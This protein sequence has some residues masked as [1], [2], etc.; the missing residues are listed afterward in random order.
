MAL[1]A[2]DRGRCPVRAKEPLGRLAAPAIA[3][4]PA[5]IQGAVQRRQEVGGPFHA[6][7]PPEAAD[8]RPPKA[9]GLEHGP[10]TLYGLAGEHHAY[11]A[12]LNDV[13]VLHRLALQERASA[14][15]RWPWLRLLVHG[16][17]LADVKHGRGPGSAVAAFALVAA[18]RV[19]GRGAV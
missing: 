3:V 16:I 9:V 18:V 14:G 7:T 6:P 11:P 8:T 2:I 17:S 19:V 5:G 12:P 10:D 1:V 4:R 15:R 13:A